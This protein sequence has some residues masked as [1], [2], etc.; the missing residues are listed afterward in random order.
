MNK[1][2]HFLIAFLAAAIA[3]LATA[4]ARTPPT[5]PKDLARMAAEHP[6]PGFAERL[7]TAARAIEEEHGCRVGVS[8]KDKDSDL[9]FSWRGDELFHPA[10][11]MKVPVMIEV[12]RQ[13]DAGNFRLHDTIAVTNKFHSM[14]DGSEFVADPRPEV[15]EFL[16]KRATVLF[17]TEQMIVV[18]DNAATNLLVELVRPQRITATM[19]AIG[20]QKGFVVRGVED[21]QAYRAGISNFMTPDGLT[22][23]ME[24]IEED[25]AGSPEA[26]N[27]MRRILLDQ[28]F[29]NLIPGQLPEGVLVGHKTG[30]ITGVRNDTGI[31]YAPFGTY[32]LTIMT[33]GS[34]DSQGIVEDIAKL[35]RLIYDE[36]AA[37]AA[38]S[39]ASK[40]G[41]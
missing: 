4:C 38:Q 5:L 33:E 24:A 8:F 22:R 41:G 15:A 16:G 35:S 23:M 32:Y 1:T 17:L 39:A 37:L 12:F 34:T 25:E 14:I 18:S 19:R 7:I 21:N 29:K 10:S 20:V 6:Y 26:C 36:R 30:S 27:E 2:C 3:L 11:T 28:R 13:I 31:V 40:V 9:A